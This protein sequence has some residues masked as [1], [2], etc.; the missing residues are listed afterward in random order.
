MNELSEHELKLISAALAIAKSECLALLINSN[1][2]TPNWRDGVTDNYKLREFIG[3]LHR[4]E[5]R[6]DK[7]LWPQEAEDIVLVSPFG[8]D[9]EGRV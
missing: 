6:V 2:F 5:A 1:A 3:E 9:R 7:S 4:L 8:M